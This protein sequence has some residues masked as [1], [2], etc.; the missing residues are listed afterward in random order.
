MSFAKALFSGFIG[1]CTLTLIHETARRVNP[2]APRMD[3]LGM[4]AISKSLRA[5]GDQPP[6]H[7]SL[8]RA[9]L[10]GDIFANT[11]YYSLVGIGR[12]NSV[13]VRGTGLGLAAG[14]GG[15]MLPV[16][17]GLGEVPS[18]KTTVTKFMTVVWYLAGALAA[19]SAYRFLTA[20]SNH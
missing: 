11:L 16:P 9:S 18:G 4:R 2:N 19:A 17:M 5:V 15:V 3:I 14:I 8:H 7:K 20:K 10:I 1:A 12:E 13:W 6:D